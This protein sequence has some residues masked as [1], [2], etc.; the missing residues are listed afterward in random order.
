M[1]RRAREKGR[2]NIER[3]Y[4]L[5]VLTAVVENEENLDLSIL[6]DKSW[7]MYERDAYHVGG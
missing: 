7:F 1:G 3:T 2:E 5:G 6:L 4:I